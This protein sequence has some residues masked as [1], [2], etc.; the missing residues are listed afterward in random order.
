MG[1]GCGQ[2]FV[3]K[4]LRSIKSEEGVR[5]NRDDYEVLEKYLVNFVNNL[6]VELQASA[7]RVFRG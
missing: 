4:Y 7:G 2:L 1:R 3:F 5:L 6:F